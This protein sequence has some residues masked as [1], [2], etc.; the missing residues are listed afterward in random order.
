M[1]L[2]SASRSTLV[3]SLLGASLVVGCATT[4]DEVRVALRQSDL[5]PQS[6]LRGVGGGGTFA[7]GG[8]QW[9]GGGGLF[10]GGG[11]FW[12]GGGG[13]WSGGG[14]AWSGGG[15]PWAGG[16]G[17]WSGGGDVA[18]GGGWWSGG[19][20]NWNGG[21]GTWGGGGNWW[22]GGG[23]A[24]GGG[25][26]WWNGG[27]G[28]FAGGGGNFA[29]GGGA[30]G[31]GGGMWGGGF[32][33]A[34]PFVGWH[35]SRNW[36]FR[37]VP[38]AGY[39]AAVLSTWPTFSGT[40]DV[41]AC[42][43]G[44]V[45]LGGFNAN[46]D[47]D[48]WPGF[49]ALGYTKALCIPTPGGQGLRVQA[50]AGDGSMTGIGGYVMN[51]V[52]PSATTSNAQR[53]AYMLTSLVGQGTSNIATQ[54]GG[55]LCASIGTL[56]AAKRSCAVGIAFS[57][58][59]TARDGVTATVRGVTVKT[60]AQS[61]V[62]SENTPFGRPDGFG[63]YGEPAGDMESYASRVMQE[64][65][66]I[67]L[68]VAASSIDAWN[69][70]N[71]SASL[72]MKGSDFAPRALGAN[73]NAT[74]L[75][76]NINR[77]VAA[78]LNMVPVDTIAA[79]T[80]IQN[81]RIAN[82][83]KSVAAQNG[84]VYALNLHSLAEQ[85]NP[86]YGSGGGRWFFGDAA[87]TTKPLL[88]VSSIYQGSMRLLTGKLAYG[89][90]TLTNTYVAD[91]SFAYADWRANP[92][93]AFGIDHAGQFPLSVASDS[94]R[95]ARLRGAL[96]LPASLR[97]EA[98][99]MFHTCAI[100]S[101][102]GGVQCW[103]ANWNGQLGNNDYN[104]S[105]T[106][107]QVVGLEAGVVA[108]ASGVSHTCA[109]LGSGAVKCWGA[110][111]NGQLGNGGTADGLTP[112]QVTGL[113]SGVIAI[114]SGGD[115]TCAVLASGGIKCWGANAAGQLGNG[116]V[117]PMSTVPVTVSGIANATSVAVGA[118]SSSCAVLSNG[119]LKCWGANDSGELGT[120]TTS[121]PV[122]T[123]VQVGSLAGV[124]GVGIGWN[125]TCALLGS[126]AVHCWGFNYQGEL[127]DGTTTDRYIPAVVPALASGVTSIA[128]G[129]AHTCALLG[130]G[131]IKCWG[132]NENGE[133]ANGTLVNSPTPST[134]L[135]TNATSL[136]AGNFATCARTSAGEVRC[137][138][139]NDFSQIG[140]P[141]F[142]RT[143][144]APGLTAVPAVVAGGWDHT[145]A[146]MA[147]GAVQCWG[148]GKQLGIGAAADGFTDVP[149]SLTP[150]QV[151]GLGSGVTSL[152]TGGYHSC[153]VQ[154]GAVKCWGQ[155]GIYAPTGMIGDGTPENRWTPAQVSGLTSGATSVV[156]GAEHSCAL[157]NGGVQCWG[158]NL[159]GQLGNS[160][161]TATV[162][163]VPIAVSGLTSGVSS[164]ASSDY[165]TC[166]VLTT[167]SV[168][169]WGAGTDGQ[170]GGAVDQPTPV[171]VAGLTSVSQLSL[172]NFH[173][174]A[175]STAGAVKCLGKNWHSRLGDGTNTDSSTPV[176]VVGLT[177]GVTSIS[178]GDSHTCARLSTGAVKCWGQNEYGQ[179]GDSASTALEMATPTQVT[180]M[181][182]GVTA[183]VTGGKHTC[184][185]LASSVK[186]WGLNAY[187]QLGYG[188]TTG[189]TSTPALSSYGL[190]NGALVGSQAS[191]LVQKFTAA[192]GSTISGHVMPLAYTMV[193]NTTGNQA[194]M[195]TYDPLAAAAAMF[196]DQYQAHVT[197]CNA[198]TS[199]VMTE[200]NQQAGTYLWACSNAT[201]KAA[202]LS[203]MAQFLLGA[204]SYLFGRPDGSATAACTAA[205]AMA[206]T[207]AYCIDTTQAHLPYTFVVPNYA[208]S[209]FNGDPAVTT[210]AGTYYYSQLDAALGTYRTGIFGSTA[211]A[212]HKSLQLVGIA[213]FDTNTS[214][215]V[216][217]RVKRS[218]AYG[219]TCSTQ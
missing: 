149:D 215:I 135:F 106:P 198:T 28:S 113:T 210:G 27:G 213:K 88:D 139:R 109:L 126:G 119:T 73:T 176:Q 137:S 72:S 182:S 6:A 69:N 7:G 31:G 128:V 43:A 168:K 52:A 49:L 166:A 41:T 207:P 79:G 17:Q 21:G 11:G 23:G 208:S 141:N 4:S 191:V 197:A 209:A 29:G 192:A 13:T 105:T 53:D 90:G 84:K 71:F 185:I 45:R 34:F 99:G 190:T 186:C 102:G 32:A 164:I 157:V 172:G 211:S 30:W 153:A 183:I 187:G 95:A 35:G 82:M 62:A 206:G 100:L 130:S 68:P 121:A 112:S 140:V 196:I 81:E 59:N 117:T 217:T 216:T 202:Y 75:L 92:T 64:H 115:E 134:A 155:N 218:G 171:V 162:S 66:G 120:G 2:R 20:G 61:G 170:L 167:G 33:T 8:G 154:S 55:A 150:V 22:S 214:A 58:P 74:A 107:V 42:A 114:A 48:G 85:Q 51:G 57:D 24:W 205:P 184:A 104:R 91:T 124:V 46:F 179:V 86:L 147:T 36:Q 177:S 189:R 163:L 199:E 110:N 180:G 60:G 132:N 188:P 44:T 25:G 178:A 125:H 146:L 3:L 56:A 16:G 26:S 145:C 94:D 194:L 129:S 181:T 98:L 37:G 122:S 127:G 175:L 195:V 18:G 5:S 169:C 174:C 108:L 87:A 158:T 131:V 78:P 165:S 212:L 111:W 219:T 19:G 77:S 89:T 80:P 123:P 133:L 39:Q 144:Q 203:G 96:E 159:R 160:S 15:G 70:T 161:P 138:G 136:V 14:G 103:G 93:G 101:V 12:S 200:L 148:V 97:S 65:T 151:V 47:A 201:A 156:A 193:N 143:P 152:A 204:K 76:A 50:T 63:L 67:A 1:R 38:K 142:S 173:T 116:T 118:E 10:A 9:G 83:S 40:A 54:Y